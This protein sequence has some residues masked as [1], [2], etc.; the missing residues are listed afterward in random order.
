[1][2]QIYLELFSQHTI[3][4]F[5]HAAAQCTT[6]D[7]HFDYMGKAEAQDFSHLSSTVDEQ[8]M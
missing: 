7:V 4:C 2:R 3:I 6:Y 1:M 8:V 5:I